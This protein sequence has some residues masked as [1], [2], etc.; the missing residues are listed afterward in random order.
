MNK[1]AENNTIYLWINNFGF[2]VGDIFKR[3][4][5]EFIV[6]KLWINKD[7]PTGIKIRNTVTL[8]KTDSRDSGVS[9]QF[10]HE[11]KDKFLFRDLNKKPTFLNTSV[12][13]EQWNLLEAW[14]PDIDD[15]TKLVAKFSAAFKG[16]ELFIAT[17]QPKN[18]GKTQYKKTAVSVNFGS[19]RRIVYT[20]G[21]SSTQ[22]FRWKGEFKTEKQLQKL[23]G[24]K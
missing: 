4:E 24:H 14:N 17:K 2:N 15:D 7:N 3:G 22:Y 21:K 13:E 23:I 19:L 10:L 12:T 18:G 11:D 5:D 16:E 1:K 8:E 9:W 6:T 20:K